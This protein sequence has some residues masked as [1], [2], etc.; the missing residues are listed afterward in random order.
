MKNN[1]KTKIA[2]LILFV[3]IFGIVLPLFNNVS[4][5]EQK[6]NLI[7]HKLQYLNTVTET[8]QIQNTGNVIDLS[9]YPKVQRYDKSKYGDVKFK[10][11]KLA[12]TVDLDQ[13]KTTMGTIDYSTVDVNTDPNYDN[14]F[15]PV[16]Q[17]V[18]DQGMITFPNLPEGNFVLAET[19]SSTGLVVTKAEPVVL[20]FPHTGDHGVITQFNIYPKNKVRT[21]NIELAKF[22]QKGEQLNGATFE[23]YKGEPGSGVKI[24]DDLVTENGKITAN[25]V[26]VGKW[27]LVE[28][29][30]A[31]IGTIA[32][33][34]KYVKTIQAQNDANNKLKFVIGPDGALETDLKAELINYKAPKIGKVLLNPQVTA[35]EK[36]YYRT[37]VNIPGDIAGTED[38]IKIGGV[39]K[40]DKT[41]SYDKFEV[42]D[43]FTAGLI[44]ENLNLKVYAGNEFLTK[45]VDYFLTETA[46]SFKIDFIVKNSGDYRVSDTVKN[47]AGGAIAIDYELKISPDA[48][49]ATELKNIAKLSAGKGPDIVD[50]NTGDPGQNTP[51]EAHEDDPTLP[52]PNVPGQTDPVN[53]SVDPEIKLYKVT[54]KTKNAGVLGT[55][56]INGAKFKFKNNKGKFLQP[57][58]QW[59]TGKWGDEA[60]AEEFV[61][62]GEDAGNPKG[63][64]ILEGLSNGTYTLVQT[65][66]PSGYKLPADVNTEVKI[67]NADVLKI[68]QNAPIDGLPYTGADKIVF[69]GFIGLIIIGVGIYLYKNK[70]KK[71]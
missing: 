22:N 20:S 39:N 67:E 51:D 16:E 6:T 35:G 3:L 57:K 69:V 60:T 2:N 64:F 58:S 8:I 37:Y 52:E 46:N 43:E 53:P 17:S 61:T 32:S 50:I 34:K 4:F 65:V 15:T 33:G 13:Y 7:V 48:T 45:D 66:A 1:I 70:D 68:I 26:S 12:S 44:K 14:S 62:A 29:D 5:A 59:A 23:L 41:D 28:K 63:E 11:F 56:Y 71:N 55:V 27:Y 40:A 19:K 49:N 18:D 30:S 10:V 25:N 36:A 21:L 9:A 38:R 42:V 24:G 31:N 54:V 47:H